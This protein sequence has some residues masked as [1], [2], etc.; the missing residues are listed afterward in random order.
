MLLSLASLCIVI[1]GARNHGIQQK[2]KQIVEVKYKYIIMIAHAKE[3]NKGHVH[4]LVEGPFPAKAKIL[5]KHKKYE[6]LSYYKIWISV[7]NNLSL[8]RLIFFGLAVAPVNLRHNMVLVV[9]TRSTCTWLHHESGYHAWLA[10][11]I[12]C[13]G[14]LNSISPLDSLVRRDWRD[15]GGG[16]EAFHLFTIET[17]PSYTRA[18]TY[19]PPTPINTYVI[20]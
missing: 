3:N 11:A 5:W 15:W 13:M 8:I 19:A 4:V 1:Q 9:F 17:W 2:K 20:V 10:I 14:T 6:S 18:Y 16:R 7:N 12:R